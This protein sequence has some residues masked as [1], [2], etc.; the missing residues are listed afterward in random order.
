MI[1]PY[2]DRPGAVV[3]AERL[4]ARIGSH[5]FLQGTSAGTLLYRAKRE[6]KDRVTVA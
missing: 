4:H 1:L 6:G 5:P 3:V 2:T